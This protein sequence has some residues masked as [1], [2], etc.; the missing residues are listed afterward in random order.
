MNTSKQRKIHAILSKKIVL[1]W[2]AKKNYEAQANQ[3]ARASIL[4]QFA[5][6]MENI[7]IGAYV[8]PK[9][10]Y[11]TEQQYVPYIYTENE[12]QRFFYQTDQCC[13]VGECPYRHLIM[14]AFFRM[15]YACGL[16]SGETR[17]LKVKDVDMDAG[18]LSI[19]H[20]KKDNS[21]LVPM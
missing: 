19:Y 18:I 3:C 15:V 7:G 20:S 9:G 5:M 8:L 16:R 6:Y 11:P 4:R 13:Y 14:P 1:E 12:L 21:R 17:L 10:Y 2:C